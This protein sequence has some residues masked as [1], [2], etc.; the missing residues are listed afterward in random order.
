MKSSESGS[1]FGL[2]NGRKALQAECLPFYFSDHKCPK[3]GYDESLKHLRKS[4]V[5]VI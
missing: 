1:V 5:K 3:Y 4:K 2:D